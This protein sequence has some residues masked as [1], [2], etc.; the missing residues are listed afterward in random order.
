ML[1]Y[2]LQYIINTTPFFLTFGADMNF[3]KDYK[4]KEGETQM[5]AFFNRLNQVMSLVNKERPKALEYQDTV[6]QVKQMEKQNKRN[7]ATMETFK[8]GQPVMIKAQGLLGKLE[9]RYRGKFTIKG[10]TSEGNYILMN[11]LGHDVK[12]SYPAQKLKPIVENNEN[13]PEESDE[14]IL[15]HKTNRSGNRYLVKWKGKE[16]TEWIPED[17][18]DT[19]EVI[20]EYF[21]RVN[22][23]EDP[24]EINSPIEKS[25]RGRKKNPEP[26]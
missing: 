26:P 24:P 15:D 20:N 9:P 7:H 1:K 8:V 11:A 16:E 4:L 22:Q 13:K 19:I 23:R 25:K 21:K 3:F 17:H 6:S 14:T 10:M 5:S 12:D 2:Q 18:F